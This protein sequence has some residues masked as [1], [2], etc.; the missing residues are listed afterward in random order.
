MVRRLRNVACMN[1]VRG[2]SL[3]LR[4]LRATETGQSLVEFA[5][6]LPLF[7]VLLFGLVDF[8]R[9]FYSWILITNAAREGARAGA[10][11]MDWPS[12]QSA[13][14]NSICNPYPGS[15]SLDTSQMV[16]TSNGVQGARGS[17]V[18]VDITY[19][20]SYATP[21]GDL[22]ALL[23]GGGSLATPLLKAHSSMRLE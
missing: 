9:A 4:R 15:C 2:V 22:M 11:Q 8:G 18:S 17:Q 19:T 13:A 6:V 10:V 7:L 1:P 14:Y 20:F 5:M 16:L 3:G 21:L 23:P 12:M